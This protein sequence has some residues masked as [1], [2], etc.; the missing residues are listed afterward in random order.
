MKAEDGIHAVELVSHRSFFFVGQV[1][2]LPAVPHHH[3]NEG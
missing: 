3:S 2:G 1:M